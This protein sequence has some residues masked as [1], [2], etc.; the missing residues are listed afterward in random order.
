ML[1]PDAQNIALDSMAAIPVIDFS[2][3]DASLLPLISSLSI[4]EFRIMSIGELGTQLND[5][6]ESD[7]S[8][9]S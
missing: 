4:N 6:W 2:K 5:R 7:I 9:L 8:T 1:S 3:L